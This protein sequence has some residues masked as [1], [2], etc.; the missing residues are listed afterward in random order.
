[1]P[2]QNDHWFHPGHPTENILA[3]PLHAPS[4]PPIHEPDPLS[5]KTDKDLDTVLTFIVN[6]SVESS[7]VQY[8][9]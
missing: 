5:W 7:D 2:P 6:S 3:P 4:P 8:C 1:M 9:K